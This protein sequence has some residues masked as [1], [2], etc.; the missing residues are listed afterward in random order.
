MEEILFEE[1]LEFVRKE[2]QRRKKVID[3]IKNNRNSHE[4]AFLVFSKFK[5]ADFVELRGLLAP[6]KDGPAPYDD[7]LNAESCNELLYNLKEEQKTGAPNSE[8]IGK[9]WHIYNR[10]HE[11][12][13]NISGIAKIVEYA[14]DFDAE[15]SIYEEY[16]IFKGNKK[17]Q[18]SLIS[19]FKKNKVVLTTAEFSKKNEKSN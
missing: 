6:E 17:F 13:P 16:V 9:W 3:A 1:V 7:I 18:D 14:S 12:A 5:A 8:A 2:R 4:L 11:E 15:Y 10:R 19:F